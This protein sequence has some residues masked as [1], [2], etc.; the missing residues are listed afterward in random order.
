MLSIVRSKKGRRHHSFNYC[1]KGK[2]HKKKPEK[3]IRA[4]EGQA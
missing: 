1:S 4:R 2:N 3:P